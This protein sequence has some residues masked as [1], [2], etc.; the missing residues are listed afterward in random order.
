MDV[1]GLICLAAVA[2]AGCQYIPGTDWQRVA[3]A[4]DAAAAVLIDPSSAQ[5]RR[6]EMGRNGIVCGEINGKNRMG[7]YVGFARFVATPDGDVLIDPQATVTQTDFDREMEE[8][9][10]AMRNRYGASLVRL[11]LDRAREINEELFKQRVFDS[12]WVGACS[13][14]AEYSSP[15]GNTK[16]E[17]PRGTLLP[18]RAPVEGEATELPTPRPMA[19]PRRTEPAGELPAA[20]PPSGR[21]D[22]PSAEDI[23]AINERL[24]RFEAPFASTAG[25]TSRS[26]TELPIEEVGRPP[27]E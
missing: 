7:A 19:A 17:E 23:A 14:A 21:R 13:F 9:Q 5:F 1:R 11:R 22:P 27:A 15:G 2:L 20:A 12:G 25:P 16:A 24:A 10:D 3:K 18:Q 26:V 4:K 6:V 8:A